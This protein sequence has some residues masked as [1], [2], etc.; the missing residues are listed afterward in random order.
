MKGWCKMINCV[1]SEEITRERRIAVQ[2]IR[3][4]NKGCPKPRILPGFTLRPDGLTDGNWYLK[5]T[6]QYDAWD[7]S[8]CAYQRQYYTIAL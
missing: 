7:E 3:A 4:A 8:I 1:T 5:M 2:N 6:V